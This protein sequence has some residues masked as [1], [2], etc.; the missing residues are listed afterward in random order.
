MAE[1]SHACEPQSDNAT[2]IDRVRSVIIQSRHEKRPFKDASAAA[3][4][5][6]NRIWPRRAS[7]KRSRS[8]IIISRRACISPIVANCGMR[9]CY[10]AKWREATALDEC[11]KSVKH[12]RMWL[13]RPRLREGEAIWKRT[14]LRVCGH[15]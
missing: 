11:N 3:S 5:D 1:G 8:W 10:S 9:C 7:M 13:R 12:T 2:D 6:I 15:V 14:R 4:G